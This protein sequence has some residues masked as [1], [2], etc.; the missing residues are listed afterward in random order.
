[1]TYTDLDLELIPSGTDV[2]TGPYY[3]TGYVDLG[4]SPDVGTGADIVAIITVETY[5]E[6]SNAGLTAQIV[7]ASNTALTSAQTVVG[8]SGTI[9]AA[10]LEAMDDAG[11]IGYQPI[12]V[13]INPNH[14]DTLSTST[15]GVSSDVGRYLGLK[16]S[17]TTAN[18]G[19]I[20]VHATFVTNWTSSPALSWHASGSVIA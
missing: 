19:A 9:T 5:T 2:S 14:W 20:T 18:P 8:N 4:V 16:L 13:R 17:Y 11:R 1:M 6:G 10:E 15:T 3:S 12:I 7:T